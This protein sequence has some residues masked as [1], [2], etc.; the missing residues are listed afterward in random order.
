MVAALLLSRAPLHAQG[1]NGVFDLVSR[2]AGV[3]MLSVPADSEAVLSVPFDP[4]DSALSSLLHGQ[5][6]A[7]TATNRG[8]LARFWDA[9]SGRYRTYEKVAGDAW[10]VAPESGD[11]ADAVA[12][13]QDCPSVEMGK[14]FIV[15]N[16]Q[17]Y[18]QR[19][20]FGGVIALEQTR[21]L[22]L[23]GG[24]S[25]VSYPFSSAMPA[26][27]TGIGKT[28]ALLTGNAFEMAAGYWHV[29]TNDSEVSW[30]EARPYSSPFST[31]GV[32]RIVQVSCDPARREVTLG[33]VVAGTVG[34]KVDVFKRDLSTSDRVYG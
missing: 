18:V 6:T 25:L 24:I 11:S 19:I 14:G 13:A 12:E 26:N 27:E 7:A 33:A 28:G 34:R 10:T 30:S 15:A 9:T 5:L 3:V 21:L 22:R 29:A 16:R 4:F 1:T 32:V 20:M 2:P 31:A 23:P 8:D 17:S